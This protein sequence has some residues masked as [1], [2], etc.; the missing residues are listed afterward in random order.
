MNYDLWHSHGRI[1]AYI[2][3]RNFV[4]GICKLK[5]PFKNLEKP[6]KSFLKPRF[7][8]TLDQKHNVVMLHLQ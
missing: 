5:K 7:L 8:P 2:V 3:G 1:F 6:L 4:S